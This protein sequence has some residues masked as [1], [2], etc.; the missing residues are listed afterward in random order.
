MESRERR[1][2]GG[3]G[4]RLHGCGMEDFGVSWLLLGYCGDRG[5]D[6]FLDVSV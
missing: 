3:M 6:G 1:L 5:V 4:D 2:E